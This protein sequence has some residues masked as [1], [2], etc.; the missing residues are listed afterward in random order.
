MHILAEKLYFVNADFKCSIPLRRLTHKATLAGTT[1]EQSQSS[2]EMSVIIAT[3][4]FIKTP[5]IIILSKLYAS[6][7]CMSIRSKYKLTNKME[8]G[9]FVADYNRFGG[10][11]P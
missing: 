5:S 6:K 2:N 4:F 9:I 3:I 10:L 8:Y 7:M 1:K 11:F